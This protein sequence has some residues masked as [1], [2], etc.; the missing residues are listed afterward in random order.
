MWTST[1]CSSQERFPFSIREKNE[2]NNISPNF[3]ISK[4]GS[5]TALLKVLLQYYSKYYST[6]DQMKH[7]FG[8]G[9]CISI[10]LFSGL[11]LF[12]RRTSSTFLPSI[13]ITMSDD[14]ISETYYLPAGELTVFRPENVKPHVAFVYCLFPRWA[15]E[16]SL[17]CEW[18]LPTHQMNSQNCTLP[19]EKS[20]LSR[21]AV[22][23]LN[24]L[25]I[26]SR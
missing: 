20:L 25:R 11:Y 10:S 21:G 16:A 15:S 18:E 19:Q 13:N 4:T 23:P 7:N 12:L 2:L 5:I 22:S 26:R 1:W 6:S 8:C 9:S 3:V 14:L 24:T 17:F